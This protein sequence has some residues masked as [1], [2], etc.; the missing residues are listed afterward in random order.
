M[1]VPFWKCLRGLLEP[2]HKAKAER[3]DLECVYEYFEL[4]CCARTQ[5]DDE[6]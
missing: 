1:A 3:Y 4:H 5:A 2:A 6:P